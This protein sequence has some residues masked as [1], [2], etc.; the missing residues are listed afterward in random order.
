M[1]PSHGV[2]GECADP[3]VL[4][5]TLSSRAVTVVVSCCHTS[6]IPLLLERWCLEC[7]ETNRQFREGQ[8]STFE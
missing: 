3:R 7:S 6:F 8:K 5:F 4:S 2:R 1:F